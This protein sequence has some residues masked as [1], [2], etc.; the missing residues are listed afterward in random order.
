MLGWL[1]LRL[2]RMLPHTGR[3]APLLMEVSQD[4]LYSSCFVQVRVCPLECGG[5]CTQPFVELGH[6]VL[7]CLLSLCQAVSGFDN[8][9]R[10]RS[11]PIHHLAL[12][13]HAADVSASQSS[14]SWAGCDATT[15]HVLT[16]A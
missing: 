1:A 5:Q 6:S 13:Q 16:A 7:Q 3:W 2:A 11:K 4:L 12:V 15:M 14:V 8:E 10:C 9:S